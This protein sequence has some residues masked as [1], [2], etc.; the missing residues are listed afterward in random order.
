MLSLVIT[1]LYFNRKSD[2]M[3]VSRKFDTL[4][5]VVISFPLNRRQNIEKL[6][7]DIQTI[8]SITPDE[9]FGSNMRIFRPSTTRVKLYLPNFSDKGFS[10]SFSVSGDMPEERLV[11][12]I[13]VYGLAASLKSF[14]FVHYVAATHLIITIS[15][16]STKDSKEYEERV[17]ALNDLNSFLQDSPTADKR[18]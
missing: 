2:F 4:K 11:R 6:S 7:E 17:R 14:D 15:I 8:N 5:A 16:A 13:N 9:A 10:T 1:N 12:A 18:K 3:E